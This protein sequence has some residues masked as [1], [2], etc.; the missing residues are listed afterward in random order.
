[1]TTATTTGQLRQADLLRHAVT[2]AQTAPTRPLED[3]A[4]EFRQVLRRVL[5][6][7]LAG[8]AWE[9]LQFLHDELR[10]HK[11]PVWLVSADE[12][13]DGAAPSKLDVDAKDYVKARIGK[14]L[15]GLPYEL[16]GEGIGK[17]DRVAVPVGRLW[18]VVDPLDGSTIA[19]RTGE[20]FAVVIMVY[21][22]TA[23]GPEIVAIGL[24]TSPCGG[25]SAAIT[26]GG[27]VDLTWN[28]EEY[29]EVRAV[30]RGVAASVAMVTGG[31]ANAMRYL[32]ALVEALDAQAPAD[33]LL[34]GQP[35]AWS[36]DVQAGNP[37]L[38]KLLM[39][40][41]GLLVQAGPHKIYDA[42]FLYALVNRRDVDVVHADDGRPMTASDLDEAAGRWIGRGCPNDMRTVPPYVVSTVPGA[43]ETVRRIVAS[44]GSAK[45]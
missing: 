43:A 2:D 16:V 34:G 14:L 17:E 4:Y 42:A 37:A 19:E 11:T 30:T 9:T 23:H 27:H 1:M 18:V 32:S 36:G 5:P 21:M 44:L 6:K 29:D 38:V 22:Q 20:G 8:L 33:G 39:L 31:K 35:R 3:V 40:E 45:D 15:M 10:Q 28:G 41:L 13:N 25:S 7:E 24:A 26:H 12:A